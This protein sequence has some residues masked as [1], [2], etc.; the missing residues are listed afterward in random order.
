[1]FHA[2]KYPLSGHFQLLGLFLSAQARFGG[3][4]DPS[5]QRTIISLI[6]TQDMRLQAK[7]ILVWR[8]PVT[9]RRK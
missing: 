2:L 4:L 8:I 6:T 5:S 3:V 7:L 9:V 1:M